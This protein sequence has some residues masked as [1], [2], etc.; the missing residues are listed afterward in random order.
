[1][2]SSRNRVEQDSAQKDDLLSTVMTTDKRGYD[3][4][5]RRERAETERRATRRRVLDAAARLFVAKGYTATTIADIAREAGVAVQSVY[6]AGQS[7][8][9]LLQAVVDLAVAGDDEDIMIADR[10]EFA[11]IDVGTASR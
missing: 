7:K 5:R 2:S 4:R 9:E 3:A 10:A 6:K 1:M 8:A 11:A